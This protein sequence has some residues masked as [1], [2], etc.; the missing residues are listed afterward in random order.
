MTMAKMPR[1]RE[2]TA[3]HEVVGALVDVVVM[4]TGSDARHGGAAVPE[5]SAAGGVAGPPFPV[6]PGVTVDR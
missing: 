3:A 1:L 5:P 6:W 2:R 4:V